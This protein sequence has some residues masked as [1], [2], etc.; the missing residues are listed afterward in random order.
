M[1]DRKTIAARCQRAMRGRVIAVL[2]RLW[3]ATAVGQHVDLLQRD[4]AVADHLVEL[5]QDGPD[6]F[7]L[8]DE[9]A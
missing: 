8:V 2:T 6:P 5:G 3:S 7:L 1:S 4:E 9:I